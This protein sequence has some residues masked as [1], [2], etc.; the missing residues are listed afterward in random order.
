[1][2]QDEINQ[3]NN[4]TVKGKLIETE[5]VKKAERLVTIDSF[6]IVKT[7]Q[8]GKTGMKKFMKASGQAGGN[9]LMTLDFFEGSA[10]GAS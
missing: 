2:P 3:E 10:V 5:A 4:I 6:E 8:S 1:M 7:R 9:S